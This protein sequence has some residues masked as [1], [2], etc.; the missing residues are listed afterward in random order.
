MNDKT[1]VFVALALTP[2]A[3]LAAIIPLFRTRKA[4]GEK[5]GR[6]PEKKSALTFLLPP[7]SA[8]LIL[9]C[10]VRDFKPSAA[11]SICG[12]GVL[13]VYLSIKEICL[14][15]SAGIYEHGFIANS[16][17]LFFKDIDSAEISADGSIAITTKTRDLKNFTAAQG[18]AEKIMSAI[19]TYLSR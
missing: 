13:G 9:L 1:I 4:M 5:R 16:D 14:R 18:H 11:F 19:D 3:A 15:F 17:F 8:A 10:F 6:L 2:V 7:V 12:C